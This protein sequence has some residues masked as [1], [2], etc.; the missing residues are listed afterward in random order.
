MDRYLDFTSQEWVACLSDLAV[1]SPQCEDSLKAACLLLNDPLYHGWVPSS[2][3]FD[4]CSWRSFVENHP[5]IATELRGLDPET[6]GLDERRQREF[7][8]LLSSFENEPTNFFGDRISG[9]L[10]KALHYKKEIDNINWKRQ[11]C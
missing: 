11:M 5:D 1:L 2:F 7:E 10:L 4:R 6:L 8:A 3:S 9:W